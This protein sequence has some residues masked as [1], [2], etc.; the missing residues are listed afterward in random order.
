MEKTI[1]T[2]LRWSVF[3]IAVAVTTGWLILCFAY[4]NRLGWDGLLSLDPGDLAALLAAAAGPPVLLWLILTVIAQQQQLKTVRRVVLDM[5]YSL[6]RSLEQEEAQSRALIEAQAASERDV[7]I[8]LIPF[9]LD[10][11]AG[12]AG[13]I[14]GRLGVLGGDEADLAWA[15]HG[16]GDKHA[17]MRPF[18]ERAANEPDFAARLRSAIASDPQSRQAAVAF[19]EHID[20]LRAEVRNQSGLKALSKT[21]DEGVLAQVYA[22]FATH[23]P[24]AADEEDPAELEEQELPTEEPDITDRL[25]PQPTL[26]PGASTGT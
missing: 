21:L 20:G 14:G 10:E 9:V 11:L 22:L 2:A 13:V 26:F 1:K 7:A 25:G 17:L 24:G 4:L 16:A 8:S 3:V 18:A 19:V 15:K 23:E 12:H 5:G 6:R